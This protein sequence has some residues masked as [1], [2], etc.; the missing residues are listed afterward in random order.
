M[1]QGTVLEWHV[2]K[3]SNVSEGELLAEIES[4]KSIGEI[5]AREDGV[6]REI[7][8][9]E[10]DSVEPGVPIAIVASQDEDIAGLYEEIEG[11]VDGADSDSSERSGEDASAPA[12]TATSQGLSSSE[13][14]QTVR[15]SPRAKK[16]AEGL[17]INLQTVD[18]SGPGGAITSR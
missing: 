9:K 11:E 16:R 15:A 18:G 10:G 2:D 3:G 7:V 8:V 13:S 4:E 1:E 6:L 17:S 14:M 5:E 12:E